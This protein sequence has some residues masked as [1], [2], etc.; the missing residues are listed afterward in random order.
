[1]NNITFDENKHE[2]KVDGSVIPSV[3]QILDSNGFSDFGRVP[4]EILE[5][6]SLFGKAV[7][8]TIELHCKGKLDEESLDPELK[9]YLKAWENFVFDFVYDHQKSEIQGYN[10]K[11]RFC[12][13]FDQGGMI[14]YKKIRCACLLDIKTGQQKS[15][16]K[17]QVNGG[18]ALA[19]DKNILTGILYLNPEFKPSG[20]KIIFSMDN[21][22]DQAIFLS[23]LTIHNYKKENN[24]L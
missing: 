20:Y 19:V 7:H 17:V 2:Y 11:Y 5:R 4:P 13:T 10:E 23:A 3:T 14:N 6:S 8:K 16:D 21:K 12:Y 1:M 9:P 22:R 24:L 18:Y 15:C